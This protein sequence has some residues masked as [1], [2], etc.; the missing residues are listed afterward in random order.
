MAIG[1]HLI[2][3][4]WGGTTDPTRIELALRDAAKAAGATVLSA[5]FHPFEGGGITGV[6]LLAESHITIHTWPEKSYA[7]LDL[8]MCGTANVE[9]AADLLDRA[10]APERTERRMLPRG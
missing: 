7:A 6:L 8:F 4:H 10:L 1:Q 2:L 3:E 9:A 5:H